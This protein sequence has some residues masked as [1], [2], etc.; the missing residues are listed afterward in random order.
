MDENLSASAEFL[1]RARLIEKRHHLR[2]VSA[3]MKFG[4]P[5]QR[6]PPCCGR[7][8]IPTFSGAGSKPLIER[9]LGKPS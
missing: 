2:P 9:A 4:I 1:A 3:V 7:Y 6:E 5:P 8:K